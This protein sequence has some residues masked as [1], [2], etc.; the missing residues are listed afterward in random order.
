MCLNI[1]DW[2][3]M[4]RHRAFCCPK[5]IIER[6]LLPYR[7]ATTVMAFITSCQAEFRSERRGVSVIV[8]PFIRDRS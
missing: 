5:P 8:P 6:F 3:P 7:Q 1:Y 2:G 4:G